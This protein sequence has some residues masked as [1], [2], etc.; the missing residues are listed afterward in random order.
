MRFYFLTFFLVVVNLTEAQ[1]PS[2]RGII[3]NCIEKEPEY[4]G[5]KEGMIKLLT[6][7]LNFNAI[8]DCQYFEYRIIISYCIDTSG[9][10]MQL[11]IVQGFDSALDEEVLRV[12]KLLKR[13]HPGTRGGKRVVFC[14]RQPFFFHFTN[15][16]LL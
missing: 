10:L 6:D 5:G 3:S 11:Q 4:A 9:Q 12:M 1:F 14:N 15:N 2:D 16:E 7:S 8:P 13:W